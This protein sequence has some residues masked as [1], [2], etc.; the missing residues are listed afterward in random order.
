MSGATITSFLVKIASRCNLD[1]DYC[2]VYHHADQSWRKLPKFLAA[3][4]QQ[5]FAA[6]LAEYVR[7]RSL[8]RAAVIFHGGEP[9]LAGHACIVDFARGLRLAVGSDVQLDVGLQT[10][11]LLLTA[12]VLDAF[13]T[14]NIAVSLS[15]DGP[16]EAH[17]LHRTTRKGRSSFDR[18]TAALERLKRRPSIFAGVIAVVDASIEPEMLLEFFAGHKAPKVDFLLPD[19]HHDRLPPGRDLDPGLYERWLISAFDL[20]LDRYPELPVRTFEALLDA[21]AGLPSGTDAFGFGDVSLITLETDGSWH[22]LDVLKVAGEGATRLVGSVDD[23]SIAKVAASEGLAS[24]RRLLTKDGLSP[25]CRDCDVVEICGGGSVPHRFKNGRFDQPTVYCGE[26]RALI[27]HVA[28]RLRDSLDEAPAVPDELPDFD[29]AEFELAETSSAIME[30]LDAAALDEDLEGL[31][32]AIAAAGLD[33]DGVDDHLLGLTARRAGTVAWQR[34]RR[35]IDAGRTVCDVDGQPLDVDDDYFA[36]ALAAARDDVALELAKDDSWLRR[37]FGSGIVFEGE[38]LAAKG[39]ELVTS[40]LSIIEAWRPQLADELRSICSAIQ[41]V[42]DPTAHPDK[43]VSFSDDSVPGALF[44]SIAQGDGLIDPY[45]LADSLVHEYRHQK[46]YLFERIHP[47]TKAGALVVSPWREDM[48]PVS[49][50]L[51]AVFVFVELRRFWEY[52]RDAGP[53]R[54]HNRAVAQLEDTESNLVE[55]FETLRGCEL[56]KAGRALLEVLESRKRRLPL[57]A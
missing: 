26:M 42:R 57:A 44:V 38:A 35:L 27:R 41:F 1:C 32:G 51:H 4:H 48:R 45:D 21:V 11:G 13:E 37:P 43:I 28:K 55:A 36:Y 23:T 29:V 19:A 17:D 40:A 15:M 39:R 7:A 2:Y 54:L 24:H 9:L 8:S 49:G 14:E 33:V 25:I 53:P 12:E 3:S 34:A 56:T 52:V 16:R 22:D 20:W 31:R 50:L 10:N 30:D 47:T 5:S 46:L 6:R 18:V